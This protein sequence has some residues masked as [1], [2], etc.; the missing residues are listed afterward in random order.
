MTESPADE[1]TITIVLADDHEVVRNGL[2]M[3]LE[4][5]GDLAVV[6]EAGDVDAAMRYVRG[7][8]PEVLVLDLNMPG[9]SSL[10][11]IPMLCVESPRTAVVVLTMQKEPAFAVEAMRAGAKGYVL[12]N[13]AGTELVGAVRLAAQGETY[14]NRKLGALLATT[15]PRPF[16]PPDD[17]TERE[18]EV[19]G[20]IALGHTNADRPAA[21][22]VG[23][24]RGVTPSEPPAQDWANDAG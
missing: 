2:R 23:S 13:S 9:G 15:P 4:A 20:L 8:R 21:F 3:L 12:K 1:R 6:A 24:H 10:E 11:A 17:L 14:L 7:H 22:P 5:E 19:L 18:V 16:G